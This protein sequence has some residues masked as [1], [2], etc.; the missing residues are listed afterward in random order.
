MNISTPSILEVN[1]YKRR[2]NLKTALCFGHFSAIHPGHMKYFEYA[3]KRA[4]RLI[5]LVKGDHFMQEAGLKNNGFT[6]LERANSVASINTVD[7]VLIQGHVEIAEAIRIIRPDVFV[8]GREFEKTKPPEIAQATKSVEHYGGVVEY[9]GADTWF[10]IKELEQDF[11]GLER[12]N[13]KNQFTAACKNQNITTND[14]SNLIE[15]FEKTS[16]LVIGDTIVDKY[17]ACEAI[18]MS[19]E[20]PVIVLKELEE[21]EYLGGAAIVAS[22]VKSLGANCTFISVTGDDD[23]SKFAS[24]ELKKKS[25]NH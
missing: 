11:D 24:K 14:L 9:H 3:S 8:L 18:G 25:H 6:E 10:S 21:R 16:L 5:V 22:H 23:V 17:V 19:A 2:R 7:Q 1:E 13:R 20:A 12:D 4:E 15:Q